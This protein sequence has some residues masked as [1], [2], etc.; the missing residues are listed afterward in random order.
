VKKGVNSGIYRVFL[1]EARLVGIWTIF[2]SP[3]CGKTQFLTDMVKRIINVEKRCGKEDIAYLAFGRDAA[4]EAAERCGVRGSE[5]GDLW[6]RTLHSA[7]YRILG[8]KGNVVDQKRLR[9]FSKELGIEV[10]SSLTTGSDEWDDPH[11]AFLSVGGAAPQKDADDPSASVSRTLAL[12][13][14]SRL[15]CREEGD[16][17]RCRET[18]HPA[19]YAR[20]VSS[21]DV[22]QYRDLVAHYE[23]WKAGAGI[24]DFVDMLERVVVED[25]G[26]PEW[27]YAFVDEG[28]DLSPLQWAVIEKLFVGRV[29]DLYIGGD[30][31]QAIYAFQ[32][33]S[34][35]DFLAW[36][37]RGQVIHLPKTHRFGPQ[38]AGL[39]KEIAERLSEREPKSV[40]PADVESSAEVLWQFDPRLHPGKRFLLHRHVAGCAGLSYPL[41][42]HGI[43]FWNERGPNPLA[44]TSEIDAFLTLSKFARGV[45]VN[46]RDVAAL[47]D[48]TPSLYTPP[49]SGKIRL[50]KY[51]SKKKISE[52]DPYRPYTLEDLEQRHI[53]P[54]FCRMIRE[55]R[56]DAVGIRYADY[57]ARLEESG[58]DLKG[59]VSPDTTITTIHGSKGRESDLVFLWSEVTKRCLRDEG[60]HRVAYVGATRARKALYIVRDA[61]TLWNTVEYPYPVPEAVVD[62]V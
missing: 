30:D 15:L 53:T 28:Q 6:F 48:V 37:G 16:L 38:I 21:T 20:V 11:A 36:R 52:E 62:E 57:Y 54:E 32:G 39:A 2:G 25:V 24:F 13:Q 49:K 19:A 26:L 14:L 3:G 27:E 34:A 8:L 61:V 22:A 51:G 17:R 12:Y 9:D 58:W 56:Y 42:T 40:I 10:D 43:P 33:S 50:V 47:I 44:K 46:A 59:R 41:I 60:E 23:R 35:R 4:A 18:L 29:K 45:P 7:C 5:R 55:R 1:L 31:D